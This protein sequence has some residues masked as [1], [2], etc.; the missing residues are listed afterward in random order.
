MANVIDQSG[1]ALNQII[2]N[3]N[4]NAAAVKA[5]SGIEPEYQDIVVP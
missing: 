2:K 4:V 5:A 3:G 1:N